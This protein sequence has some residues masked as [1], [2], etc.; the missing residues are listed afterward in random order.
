VITGNFVETFDPPITIYNEIV[1]EE[2][3]INFHCQKEV[4]TQRK[5]GEFNKHYLLAATFSPS[6]RLPK[7]KKATSEAIRQPTPHFSFGN[8]LGTPLTLA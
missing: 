5:D 6:A 1:E 4:V 3:K 7:S 2:I 8:K